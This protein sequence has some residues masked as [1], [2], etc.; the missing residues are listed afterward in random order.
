MSKKSAEI[1]NPGVVSQPAQ[2]SEG[3]VSPAVFAQLLRHNEAYFAVNNVPAEDQVKRVAY[4]LLPAKIT[5]WYSSRRA[6][7]NAMTWEDFVNALRP[8][9]LDPGWALKERLSIEAMKQNGTPAHEF[10]FQVLNRSITLQGTDQELDE[11]YLRYFFH[12][13]LDDHLKR[14]VTEDATIQAI[15]DVND[16]VAAVCELDEK[17]KAEDERMDARIKKA[18]AHRPPQVFAPARPFAF[19][20]PKGQENQMQAQPRTGNPAPKEGL[21]FLGKLMPREKEILTAFSGCWRCRHYEAGHRSANCE[22]PFALFNRQP[23]SEGAGNAARAAMGKPRIHIARSKSEHVAAVTENDLNHPQLPIHARQYF[24]N[25][26]NS[27]PDPSSS[28]VVAATSTVEIPPI[29]NG[30]VY[31]YGENSSDEEYVA[32]LRSPTLSWDCLLRGPSSISPIQTSGLI[33]S[34]SSLVIID[35]SLVDRL[36]LIRHHLKSPWR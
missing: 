6:D 15:A 12:A 13:R 5:Y 33:D 1:Q 2:L 26:V 18:A 29:S 14:A 19:V 11:A 7:L 34:G 36:G 21:K 20:A 8:V 27:T 25:L 9:A 28:E 24:A 16:Y 17:L 3:I 4:S 22:V 35:E 23:L 31:E 30:G 10:W 32:P